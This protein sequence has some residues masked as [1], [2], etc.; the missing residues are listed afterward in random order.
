[1]YDVT[2]D[3]LTLIFVVLWIGATVFILG[4][5]F[6]SVLESACVLIVASSKNVISRTRTPR[7]EKTTRKCCFQFTFLSEPFSCRKDSAD[8]IN[9]NTY[10]L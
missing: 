7:R 2:V 8:S 9:E 6:T 1:M 10:C 3:C 5:S 4:L